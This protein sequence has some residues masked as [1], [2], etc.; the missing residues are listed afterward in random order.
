M[1]SRALF[2]SAE[3]P[4]QFRSFRASSIQS[5][6]ILSSLILRRNRTLFRWR[7]CL[8][9]TMASTNHTGAVVAIAMTATVSHIAMLVA[10]SVTAHSGQARTSGHRD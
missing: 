8:D 7:Q 4:Y 3:C 9:T 1:S 10:S 5:R 6:S 2:Q